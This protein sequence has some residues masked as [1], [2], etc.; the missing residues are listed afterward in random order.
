MIN[1]LCHNIFIILK[2]LTLGFKINGII[3]KMV[4]TFLILLMTGKKYASMENDGFSIPSS[5]STARFPSG[6][7]PKQLMFFVED[8]GK[9]SDLLLKKYKIQ[10]FLS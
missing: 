1:I 3:F 4:F 5:I 10:H 8:T 7:I 9:V 6:E 2:L